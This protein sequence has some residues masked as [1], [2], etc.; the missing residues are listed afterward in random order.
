MGFYTK[1]IESGHSGMLRKRE[2]AVNQNQVNN[3]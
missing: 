2:I 1:K 3:K